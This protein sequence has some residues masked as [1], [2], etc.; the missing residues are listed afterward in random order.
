MVVWKFS[1]GV[2]GYAAIESLWKAMQP[3]VSDIGHDSEVAIETN[4]DL[5]LVV[6]A[7][8]SGVRPSSEVCVRWLLK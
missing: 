6:D 1:Q 7:G 2:T 5:R 4:G 8:V 3:L